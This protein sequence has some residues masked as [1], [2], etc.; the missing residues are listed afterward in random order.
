MSRGGAPGVTAGPPRP[1]DESRP[2]RPAPRPAPTPVPARPAPAA[3]R[4]GKPGQDSPL[5][6]ARLDPLADRHPPILPAA[7][8]RLDAVAVLAGSALSGTPTNARP[9]CGTSL[10]HAL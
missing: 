6:P 8:R 3:T 4:P 7:F 5:A 10:R 9:S 2:P 1:A